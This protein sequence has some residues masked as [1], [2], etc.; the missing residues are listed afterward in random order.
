MSAE[1]ETRTNTGLTVMTTPTLRLVPGVVT[2]RR[3]EV[4]IRVV[5]RYRYT[6][7]WLITCGLA[8]LIAGVFGK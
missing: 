5:T 3:G 2:H 1:A 7:A 8:E 4:V 6:V